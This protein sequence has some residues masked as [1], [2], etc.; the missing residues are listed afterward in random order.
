MDFNDLMEK[1]KEV[2]KNSYSPYSNFPVG[3]CV[4]GESGRTY[5]GTNVENASYGGTVCAERNAIFNAITN[6]EKKIKAV[7]IY[8]QKMKRCAPC[9]FCRQVMSEFRSKDGVDI[10]I[11]A[12]D[13][14][15]EVHT[16]DELIPMSFSL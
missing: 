11:E 7:A 10:I 15:I 8:S 13:G 9:G 6:G 2:S 5:V 16:L 12:E 4:L 1:A 14:G 3:A